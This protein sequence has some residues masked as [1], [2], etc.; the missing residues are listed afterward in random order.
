[1]KN[2]SL[3][4]TIIMILGMFTYTS[5][6][7]QVAGVS[8]SI[9]ASI[10]KADAAA[11]AGYFNSTVDLEIGNTDGNFSKKQAEVIV[12][13]FFGKNP[14]QS[15]S[16]N[17]KGSSD[18]GSEYMIGSYANKSGKKYRVYILIKKLDNKYLITQLQF[19][20]D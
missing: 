7:G 10:Q 2:R 9:I 6:W 8:N 3:A 12:R 4:F 1:M 18:D 17:H 20:E 14:V 16:V 19:E 5:S 15:F 11:L 13:D